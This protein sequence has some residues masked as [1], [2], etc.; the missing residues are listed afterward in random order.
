MGGNPIHGNATYPHRMHQTALQ[1]L[2]NALETD[3]NEETRTHTLTLLSLSLST[4]LHQLNL[5]ESL[6]IFRVV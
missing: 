2:P 6:S 4:Q 3:P 5:I 1:T